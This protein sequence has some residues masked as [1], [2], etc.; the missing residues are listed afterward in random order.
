MF[1]KT[2][3]Y[4]LIAHFRYLVAHCCSAGGD[5]LTCRGTLLNFSSV[6]F[7]SIWRFAISTPMVVFFQ[8]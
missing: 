3:F 5:L 2:D 6:Y 4:F 1:L 7:I 8:G